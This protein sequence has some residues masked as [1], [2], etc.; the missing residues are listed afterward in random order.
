MYSLGNSTGLSPP[1]M[2]GNLLQCKAVKRD[3]RSVTEIASIVL[4]RFQKVGEIPDVQSVDNEKIIRAVVFTVAKRCG[5]VKNWLEIERSRLK[6]LAEYFDLKNMKLIYPMIK[7]K[8]TA[9]EDV[10]QS[11]NSMPTVNVPEEP[12]LWLNSILARE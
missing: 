9:W 1:I 6:Q 10:K 12:F 7:S 5:R 11:Y 2:L 3:V 4:R 8:D